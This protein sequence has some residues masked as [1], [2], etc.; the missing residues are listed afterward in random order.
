MLPLLQVIEG[1]NGEAWLEVHGKPMSP[2]Q[3]GSHILR[4]MRETAEQR[5]GRPVSHA[6]VTVPAYFNDAQRSATKEAG[7][8]AGLTIQVGDRGIH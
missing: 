6:V 1:P 5:L 7:Q 3:L 2:A 4:K 8:L